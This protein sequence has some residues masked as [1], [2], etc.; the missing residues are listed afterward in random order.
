MEI[1]RAEASLGIQVVLSPERQ[2]RVVVKYFR[3][4]PRP[5]SVLLSPHVRQDGF[6]LSRE[7]QG[8]TKPWV[9][10]SV[11]PFYKVPQVRQGFQNI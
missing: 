11:A 6:Q 9:I 5:Q 4:S 7:V 8:R 2:N 10:G 1:V 3:T